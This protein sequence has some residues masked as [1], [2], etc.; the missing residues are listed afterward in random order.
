MRTGGDR[1]SCAWKKLKK[2]LHS[3]IELNCQSEMTLVIITGN[4][5]LSQRHQNF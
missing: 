3:L 4:D 2:F 5:S 1:M